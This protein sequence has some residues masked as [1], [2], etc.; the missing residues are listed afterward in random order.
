[1][2]YSALLSDS[3]LCPTHTHT[4]SQTALG[5]DPSVWGRWPCYICRGL[6]KVRGRERRRERGSKLKLTVGSLSPWHSSYAT[7]AP[8]T[9][10]ISHPD[11]YGQPGERTGQCQCRQRAHSVPA[12]SKTGVWHP[13]ASLQGKQGYEAGLSPPIL[14]RPLLKITKGG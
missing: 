9:T 3:G 11:I 7:A 5:R 6:E 12:L 14:L 13:V 2:Q 1:M 8:T 10:I 4:N